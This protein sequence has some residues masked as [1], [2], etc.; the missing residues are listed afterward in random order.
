[1]EKDQWKDQVLNSIKGMERQSPSPF[2]FTRIE[3]R[4][5][6][7]QGFIPSWKVS[8]VFVLMIALIAINI[9]L[10]TSLSDQGSTKDYQLSGVQSY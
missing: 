3:A 1:M 4:L 10:I 9:A 7:M 8:I 6:K 2:L 5:G